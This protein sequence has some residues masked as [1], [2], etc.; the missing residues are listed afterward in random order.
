MSTGAS[1]HGE[2]RTGHLHRSVDIEDAE[3]F[4]DLPMGDP[5]MFGVAAG[6]VVFGAHD[7]V[8]V[9]SEAVGAS[10]AGMFA[11]WS[12]CWR[13]AACSSS[14]SAASDFSRSRAPCSR[15]LA[16]SP[17]RPCRRDAAPRS[18]STGH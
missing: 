12:S 15:L 10:G 13:S 1:V 17:H 4:A 5:L 2:H 9:F 16:R 6:V 14:A 7:D 3:L 11:M 8:V 18:L